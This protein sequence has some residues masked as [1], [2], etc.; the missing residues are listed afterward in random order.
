MT[1]EQKTKLKE[2]QENTRSKMEGILTQEQKEQLKVAVEQNKDQRGVL[3]NL[4]LHLIRRKK[5]RKLCSHNAS[6]SQTFLQ[7]NKS[8]NCNK[9]T[10]ENH[11]L[12]LLDG[13]IS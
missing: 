7:Q 6:N 9:C 4:N 3:Q 13:N 11:F 10:K 12:V 1:Q 5:Y 2:V 8:N